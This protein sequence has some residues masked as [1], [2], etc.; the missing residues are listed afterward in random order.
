LSLLK[1]IQNF[2]EN[3]AFLDNASLNFIAF[4][5]TGWHYH[6]SSPEKLLILG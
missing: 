1:K 2:Y 3:L 6:N 4:F 5:D